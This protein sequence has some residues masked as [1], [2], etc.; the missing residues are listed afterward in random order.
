MV[1]VIPDGTDLVRWHVTSGQGGHVASSC[2]EQHGQTSDV[3]HLGDVW[4]RIV[5]GE[6]GR[7][8]AQLGVAM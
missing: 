1:G 6:E 7:S 4:K 2:K 8:R 3:L 5:C